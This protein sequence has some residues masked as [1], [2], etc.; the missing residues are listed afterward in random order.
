M[1]DEK[2]ILR[3]LNGELSP[4]ELAVFK[5]SE[6]YKNYKHIVEVSDVLELPNLN[7]DAALND[8][9]R[10]ISNENKKTSKVISFNRTL[11]FKVAAS[12]VL[13]VSIF[14]IF[15]NNTTT[16]EASYAENKTINL[17]DATEITLNDGS[18]ISYK[19][20]KFEGNRTLSLDGEAF[21][22]VSKKGDFDVKTNY[23]VIHVLGTTFNIK[24]RAEIFNVFCFTGTVKVSNDN[25]DFILKPGEGVRL[26]TEKKLVKYIDKT[27]LKPYWMNNESVFF[28]APY[29]AVLN[30]FERQY[31]ITLEYGDIDT[32]VIYTG[33]FNN[34]DMDSAIQSITLPLNLKFKLKE[35][36]IEI[37]K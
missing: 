20:S 25:H 19:P 3:W 36:T 9:K 27:K 26:N 28:E 37:F 15:N 34:T 23:G 33:G 8:F 5:K 10:R 24:S 1:K 21:F 30:E 2:N 12:V 31:N 18:S 11:F 13:L 16:I 35:N 6:D 17:P 14:Y 32:S 22:D 7:V 4:E 29:S